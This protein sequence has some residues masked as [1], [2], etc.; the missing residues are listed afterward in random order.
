MTLDNISDFF[1]PQIRQVDKWIKTSPYSRLMR[2]D[3]PVGIY[4]VLLPAL[5]AIAFA[6]DNTF[7]MLWLFLVFT[8]GAIVIR[9]AG[10]ILNDLADIE[11][12]KK[13]A[14]TKSRPLA[15][16]ELSKKEAYKLLFLLLGVG[17]V[18]L[19]T[20]PFKII[21][22]GLLSII[23]IAAYP[24]FKRFTFYPQ[25]VL[26]LV[27]NLGVFMGWYSADYKPSIVPFILY[28]ACVFWTIAYDTIYAHQDKE[29]DLAAGVMSLAIKL[30]VDTK[31]VIWKLYL[32]TIVLLAITGMNSHMNFMFYLATAV[33]AYHLYWQV[34]TLDINNPKDCH[35]KFKSNVQF[36]VIILV[37]I[38]V[39][40]V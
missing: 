10:C 35:N 31:K 12:D 13:V 7:W 4:L 39:G 27:F 23:P 16:G 28:A 1:E 20:L 19:I 34:E 8:A 36:A 3:K 15:G 14:R 38:L 17:F 24:Y 32:I 2:L 25:V 33:G 37:G 11:F 26:G 40:R 21:I 30:G 29:D 9:G 18:L 6:A 5:W 22:L